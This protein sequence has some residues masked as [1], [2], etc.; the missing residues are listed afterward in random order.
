MNPFPFSCDNKRYHTLYYHN[1]SVYGRRIYKAVLDAHLTCPNR[2][3]SAGNGGCIFCGQSET[4]PRSIKEQFLAEKERILRKD[5]NA[6]I[7][8]YFGIHTNTYCTAE[9]LADMINT[10]KELGA[11]ALSL[12]TR[13]DCLDE[14]KIRI[15]SECPLPLTVELGLQTIHDST[16]SAINRCHTFEDFLRGYELLK[17]RKIRTCVHLINGLPGE[18]EDMMLE[19]AQRVGRLRPEAVKI[20]MMYVLRGT[21]LFEMYKSGEY[22]PL[23]REQYIDI[24]VK[25]LELLPPETVIERVT[26]DGDK[27]L[28]EA[29]LWSMDK[30]A[31]LGGIDKRMTELDT[32]QGK[33]FE[34]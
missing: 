32:C 12:A 3:G 4:D 8:A 31:V 17:S 33:Y 28:V 11:F 1:M 10:A 2:D 26:G 29:P 23:T 15:L 30:I 5:P 24:V 19:T 27:A 7:T 6:G 21:R 20:H 13:P 18:N 14:E 25:Q 9:Y 34:V 22:L 16:A